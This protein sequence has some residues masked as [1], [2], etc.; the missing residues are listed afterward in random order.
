MIR[1]FKRDNHSKNSFSQ[2]GEDVI[3]DFIFYQ[4]GIRKPSYLDIGAHHPSYLSNTYYF[5]QKGSSGLCIE[6][7][8]TLYQEIK[9][10]RPRDIC[11]N[12]GIGSRKDLKN[13]YL[14]D[15][16]TLNTFSKKEAETY[17][18]YHGN[19]I[20][21]IVKIPML[22]INK[23]IKN[24]LVNH[25]NFVSIDTE[26]MDFEII[27]SFDL[28]EKRPEVFCIETLIQT[29]NKSFRKVEEII[30]HM[31]HHDYFIYADTLINTI[32]VDKKVWERTEQPKLNI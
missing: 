7:D 2:S 25:P 3:I 18:R 30:K 23:V 26:G 17:Q 21:K 4:L 16:S 31:K 20:L 29:G 28:S 9:K 5:Y 11:L 27:K 24:Y 6:P 14:M 15:E 10:K 1:L 19:Q 22:P 8:P 12:I 32:F 13:F